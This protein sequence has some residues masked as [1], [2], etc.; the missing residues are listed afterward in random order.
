MYNSD[1]K[2]VLCRV[3]K[4]KGICLNSFISLM[5][6]KVVFLYLKLYDIIYLIVINVIHFTRR[7][8]KFRLDFNLL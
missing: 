6:N 4:T 3:K 8:I 7:Y 5:V 1:K 2:C